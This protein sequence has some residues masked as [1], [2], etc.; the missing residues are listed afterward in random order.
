MAACECA[1]MRGESDPDTVT[2]QQVRHAGEETFGGSS[3]DEA[4]EV[5]GLG[6]TQYIT[7]AVAEMHRRSG[8]G[9]NGVVDQ[10]RAAQLQKAAMADLGIRGRAQQG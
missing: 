10:L 7:E 6:V 5:E 8:G 9:L 4:Q 2:N 3:E 1:E